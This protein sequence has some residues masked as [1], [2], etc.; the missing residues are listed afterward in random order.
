MD[1]HKVNRIYFI[2]I[3]GIGM[4]ALARYFKHLNKIVSG[5]D[6][7]QTELTDQLQAEGISI[8]FEDDVELADKNADFVIYTPAIPKDHK[9]Y[10]FYLSNNYPLFKR[11][12]MLGLL[13]ENKFTIAV[14]GS[15][16][17]TTVS[18]MIAWILKHSGTDCSAFL[19]GI[20]VNFNSN[21]VAGD[22]DIVVVEAD[23]FDRSFLQLSP[24]ITV[25]TAVDSDH[26]EIYG[27]QQELEKTFTVF[28]NNLKSG[29][30]LV[31]KPS[32]SILKNVRAKV[33]KY[34]L[35]DA[36]ADL[37]ATSYFI[38]INGSDVKLNNGIS[39]H[40]TYPGIH[41]IEN[42][43]A[44]VS[45]CMQLTIPHEK[46]TAA[47]EEFKGIHRR[48]EI[49]FRNNK[50]IFIDDYAHHPEEIRMFLSSVKKIYPERKVT[51][52]FQPHLFTRT[53]DLKEGFAE[54]LDIA[55]EV[56]LLPIY[57]ARELPI[58]NVTTKIIYDLV[59]NTNK[60]LLTKEEL[61]QLIQREDFEVL[62]TIGAGDIDK[63]V[64]PIAEI[65]RSKN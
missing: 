20:S 6:R 8:H 30:T 40:L 62:C 46:I 55:D 5:Y 13:T 26:L 3:G 36:S 7:T 33:W 58:E 25:I 49:M 23:E 57:P 17:K 34:A 19:G 47:L 64:K 54:S 45:V 15:H 38:T 4:S 12:K 51:A 18:S 10:N 37:F 22:N 39:Y 24:D 1:L 43:V 65:L 29:G 42:S 63:L 53:R 2:G 16:G 21:F 56:I 59:K 50:T 35:S 14:A 32:L 27:T 28:A 9:E 44:A 31:A 52:I 41:N 48:F 60:Q 11:S 61:V